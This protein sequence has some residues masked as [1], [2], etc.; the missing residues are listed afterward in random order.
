MEKRK[1]KLNIQELQKKVIPAIKGL[2]NKE[3][4]SISSIEKTKEGWILQCELLEKKSVPEIFDLLKIFE[5][6]LDN[7]GNI[8]S[9]KQIKKIRRG[10]LGE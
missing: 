10:E 8:L 1:A 4:E 9:F 6:M 3:P 7:N 5:F 2:L